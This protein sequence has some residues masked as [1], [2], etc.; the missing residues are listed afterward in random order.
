MVRRQGWLIQA[1]LQNTGYIGVAKSRCALPA[2][3]PRHRREEAEVS[4]SK[5]P[6]ELSPGLRVH[7]G[8]MKYRFTA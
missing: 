2:L 8:F 6:G 1:A 7:A 4:K 3:L 5:R